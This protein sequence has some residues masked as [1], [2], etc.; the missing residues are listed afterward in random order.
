MI[1]ANLSRRTVALLS[2]P[3]RVH[4]QHLNKTGRLILSV[5]IRLGSIDQRTVQGENDGNLTTKRNLM[6]GGIIDQAGKE[7]LGETGPVDRGYD[8]LRPECPMLPDEE[9]GL[10]WS[11]SRFR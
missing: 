10:H 6:K 11:R 9:A 5:V 2:C 4:T 7:G 8:S 1:P 3:A